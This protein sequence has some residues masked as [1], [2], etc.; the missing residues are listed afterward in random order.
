MVNRIWLNQQL[1]DLSLKVF[2]FGLGTAQRQ[3]G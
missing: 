2:R 3:L 1:P